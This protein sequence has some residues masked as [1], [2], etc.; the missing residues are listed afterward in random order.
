MLRTGKWSHL[1]PINWK[2]WSEIHSYHLGYH[3]KLPFILWCCR[4]MLACASYDIKHWYLALKEHERACGG[5]TK[6][7][8]LMKLSIKG[9]WKSNLLWTIGIMINGSN[10][11]L[12]RIYCYNSN[13]LD[14][15]TGWLVLKK[16]T[17]IITK[18]ELLLSSLKKIKK[19]A[20]WITLHCQ[21]F[22]HFFFVLFFCLK[23]EFYS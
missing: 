3:C 4:L 6:S 22:A 21:K 18:K 10:H 9:R 19:K 12:V 23:E 1:P 15:P 14:H 2:K 11:S 5:W 16:P 20:K 7:P 8:W 17:V 13:G